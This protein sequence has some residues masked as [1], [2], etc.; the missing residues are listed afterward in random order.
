MAQLYKVWR[1]ST[2][3]YSVASPKVWRLATAP[4]GG[5]GVLLKINFPP[6]SNA[7]FFTPAVYISFCLQRPKHS[8]HV[9]QLWSRSTNSVSGDSCAAVSS[10]LNLRPEFDM[11]KLRFSPFSIFWGALLS[12][13]LTVAVLSQV[14]LTSGLRRLRSVDEKTQG[15]AGG[16]PDI[17]PRAWSKP[18]IWRFGVSKSLKR[19]LLGGFKVRR[20]GEEGR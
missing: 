3:H 19:E 17:I 12:C 10:Q 13:E 7:G 4:H 8:F 14:Y 15:G 9:D 5:A 11:T 2:V 20:R 1:S 6:V 16:G 18:R